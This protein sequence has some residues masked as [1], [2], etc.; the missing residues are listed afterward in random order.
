MKTHTVKAEHVRVDQC[1]RL[2]GL[3]L[4]INPEHFAVDAVN[5]L[6]DV[7]VWK[8]GTGLHMKAKAEDVNTLV[9]NSPGTDVCMDFK[10]G[11]L[12]VQ[13]DATL[14]RFRGT[15][16]QLANPTAT[17]GRLTLPS[18]MTLITVEDA[19]RDNQRNVSCIPVGTY[20]CAPRRFNRGGYDA[21]EIT[22]VP[23]RTHILIHKGNTA[24][25][26]N[27]CIAPGIGFA[28]IQ[29]QLAVHSS[30]VAFQHIM[31][32]LG[33]KDFTLKISDVT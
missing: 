2:Q 16:I 17:F 9:F 20:H 10:S 6:P 19:W 8:A 23:G 33:G 21:I 18:G 25:D 32:E 15:G 26:L 28:W 22:N 14:E 7:V 12:E 24:D 13:P 30:S 31:G 3:T 29:K 27:G 11:N 1:H 5:T 4:H